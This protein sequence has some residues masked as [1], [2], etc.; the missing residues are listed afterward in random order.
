[1]D[2]DVEEP[3]HG[4]HGLGVFEAYLVG[5]ASA[6]L[7]FCV[8]ECFD[9]DPVGPVWGGIFVCQCDSVRG[10]VRVLVVRVVGFRVLAGRGIGPC[11]LVQ[12]IWQG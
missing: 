7:V 6:A 3:K 11:L 8:S 2:A 12:P 9:C 4:G 1:M 10:W 5:F